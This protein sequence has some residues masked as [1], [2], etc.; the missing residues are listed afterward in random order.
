M[1]THSFFSCYGKKYVRHA[2]GRMIMETYQY[3]K[4]ITS[5]SILF[6]VCVILKCYSVPVVRGGPGLHLQTI[7]CAAASSLCATSMAR[8][9][10]LTRHRLRILKYRTGFRHFKLKPTTSW[11]S[12]SSREGLSCSIA[13][14]LRPNKILS[15]QDYIFLV[16]GIFW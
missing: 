11:W 3:H 12:N 1:I 6:Q 16:M 13:F 9:A 2:S 8:V 7:R 15:K 14:F 5:A 4:I 10:G